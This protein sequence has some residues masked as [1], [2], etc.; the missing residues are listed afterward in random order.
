[1]PLKALENPRISEIFRGYRKRLVAGLIRCKCDW[2]WYMVG[3]IMSSLKACSESCQT[4]Q[5][6]LFTKIVNGQKPLTN[7]AKRSILDVWQTF[8]CMNLMNKDFDFWVTEICCKID[9]Y[10]LKLNLTP[11]AL[12]GI[13]FPHC[14]RMCKSRAYTL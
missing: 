7:S 9:R 1:M 4:T 8:F 5:M 6:K 3:K 10:A 14:Q 13:N 2:C 12:L 11:S